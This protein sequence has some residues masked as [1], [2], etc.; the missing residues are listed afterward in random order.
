METVIDSK[1]L[2]PKLSANVRR[3]REQK[4]MSQEILAERLGIS[5][6]H[7]NRIEKAKTS[8]SAELLYSLADVLGVTTDQLRQVA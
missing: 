3:L 5:R 2:L 8:P 1:E 6:V 4:D 7:L